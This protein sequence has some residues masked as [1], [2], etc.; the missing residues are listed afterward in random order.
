MSNSKSLFFLDADPVQPAP[1]GLV[2]TP[3]TPG[4]FTNPWYTTDVDVT[5]TGATPT[6]TYSVDGAAS[7]NYIIGAPI[8]ISG[9]GGHVITALDTATNIVAELYVAIDST[10][11]T[12]SIPVPEG[13][14]QGPLPVTAT[15][16]DGDGAGV[17]S[18]VA[19]ANGVQ[20]GTV[21]FDE[22]ARRG[23]L[24]TS[25]TAQGSTTITF[26][27]TDAA[28]NVKTATTTVSIDNVAPI[29]T[30]EKSPP[31]EFATGNVTVNVLTDTGGSL[32]S[33]R[34]Y[35]VAGDAP[36][37]K[38]PL[39]EPVTFEGTT[40]V[41][42]FAMDAAGNIGQST[43]PTTIKI[44][45][46]APAPTLTV[47][48]NVAPIGSSVSADFSCVDS[49]SGVA[50][51]VLTVD[52]VVYSSASPGHGPPCRR[53]SRPTPTRSRSPP[54]TSPATPSGTPVLRRRQAWSS[55]SSRSG[56]S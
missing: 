52:G 23:E 46:T 49:F 51:C 19:S 21:T 36:G 45:K 24:T 13:F 26:V 28:G 47:S 22:P 32:I 10:A 15:F 1:L 29:V 53:R 35:T 11:P 41:T 34:W 38:R 9:D 40:E 27:A 30:V 4:G 43:P 16:D 3:V 42:G 54:P 17:T 12:A 25:I 50:S 14:A 2:P 20:I 56:P 33:E 37:T 39:T 48:S 55:S 8:R 31:T 6:T 5:I 44:D 18:I 7:E